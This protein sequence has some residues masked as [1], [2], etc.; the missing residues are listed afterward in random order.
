MRS[1]QGRARV[2]V[3]GRRPEPESESGGSC[4]RGPPEKN[5]SASLRDVEAV[6]VRSA[7]EDDRRR[8]AFARLRRRRRRASGKFFELDLQA[9][10]AE[11]ARTLA[12]EIADKVLANP[13]IESYRV[14]ME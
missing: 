9:A 5:E 10:S 11:Q 2:E 7:G 4:G 12:A 13:V 8:A 6:R 1:G 14:E 3:E